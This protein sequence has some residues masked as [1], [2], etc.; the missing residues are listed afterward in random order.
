MLE[1]YGE[2]FMKFDNDIKDKT[3]YN[4]NI[5][6]IK[7]TEKTYNIKIINRQNIKK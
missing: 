3:N 5:V 7:R 1:K 6:N 2:H 4:K